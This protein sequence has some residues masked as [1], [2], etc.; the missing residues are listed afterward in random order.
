MIDEPQLQLADVVPGD[1]AGH[2][3]HA[4]RK[5]RLPIDPK[6]SIV[7]TERDDRDAAVSINNS[8]FTSGSTSG[9]TTDLVQAVIL[10]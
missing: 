9:E 5:H 7:T 3:L 6:A 1:S 10:P 2:I 8:T 4:D